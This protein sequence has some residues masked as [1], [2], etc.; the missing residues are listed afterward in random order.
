M[1]LEI[2]RKGKPIPKSADLS[3]ATNLI[4]EDGGNLQAHCH[5]STRASCGRLQFLLMQL[6]MQVMVKMEKH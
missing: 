2:L 1:H 6:R 4:G 3:K 5:K